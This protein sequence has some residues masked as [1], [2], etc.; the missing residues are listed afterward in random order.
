MILLFNNWKIGLYCW[1]LHQ[2]VCVSDGLFW[3]LWYFSLKSDYIILCSASK[4]VLYQRLKQTLWYHRIF[5]LH[6]RFSTEINLQSMSKIIL[7]I[8]L[9]VDGP[10]HHD[11]KEPYLK[12]KIHHATGK[13]KRN[14]IW[15]IHPNRIAELWTL[16]KDQWITGIFSNIPFCWVSM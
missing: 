9:T 13:T 2:S 4:V 7:K 8:G 6:F 15:R 14:S 11:R 10:K 12:Q 16:K 3:K 5:V 1:K